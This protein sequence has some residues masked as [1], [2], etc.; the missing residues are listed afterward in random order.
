M[1]KKR[2]AVIFFGL[3][4][5]QLVAQVREHKVVDSLNIKAMELYV[6]STNKAMELLGKAEKIAKSEK[7][8]ESLGY[9]IN[10]LAIVY[11]AKGEYVK[12]K[13]LSQEALSLVKGNSVKASTFNNIGACNRSLGL[14][15][16]S[17]KN[18]LEALKIY[19][20]TNDL[21]EQGIVNN[22]IGMIYSSLEMYDKA[23]TYHNKALSVY[24]KLNYKKG[25]SEVYN[26]IAIALANQDSLQKSLLYFKF[27]LK[28]EEE[29]K[30]K[31]GIAESI[32]NVGGVYHYLGKT[33]S[34][35]YYY[36]KSAEI[37]RLIQN[38][39]GVATSYNNIAQLMLEEG[40][41]ILAKSYIDSS[42]T[43]SKKSKV[44][45]SLLESIQNYAYYFETINDFKNANLYNKKYYTMSDS[46]MKSSN[47]KTLHELEVKYQTAK[48]DTEIAQNRAELAENELKIKQKNTII[49]GS[50]G[51]AF[52]LGLLGYLLYNQQKIKNNQLIKES[53]L[54]EAL[55]K[56]ETQNKL[57]EQ[58]LQISRDLHDNIGSQLT[59]IIS[60][61]DNLKYFDVAKEKLVSKFDN[62]SGFTK[63]T[64]T[65]LRDT[66]WAMNKNAI[67]VED[68]QIRITNF[69]DNAQLATHGISFDFSFDDSVNASHEFSSI[70]GMNI[71]RII[72]E[73]V[74]NAVKYANASQIK[75]LL[76]QENNKM[77][78]SIN[79]NGIGF[80]EP[81]IELG[82]GL[83]NM[84]KRALELNADLKIISEKDKGTSILIKKEIA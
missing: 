77:I 63:N 26:N 51:F 38:F 42:Y 66:I 74:N 25:L 24:K 10:N 19:E 29:L 35:L 62:I 28:I 78:F 14:Y 37:E 36:K 70:E 21:K 22:N 56:I 65:E 9:T 81:E 47:L 11:R 12:S 41:P 45:E 55:V 20:A 15:E 64:I 59:F 75:I 30:D 16:E 50:L 7:L 61:I 76:K 23:K 69:I 6:S 52:V 60:S 2:I 27:S 40:K 33:D 43:Y 54:K 49:F 31:K 84:K 83:N 5:I 57:Q 72:Q 17:L 4:C 82:N 39:S 34:A 67:S 46:I 13:Q 18:Y 71:Y 53:E 48:K 3:F 32:N 80:S 44:A 8:D 79:D 68:L 73:A 1:T 58:R